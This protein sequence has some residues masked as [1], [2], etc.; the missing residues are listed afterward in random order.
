M[1]FGCMR[2]PTSSETAG[3]DSFV[4]LLIAQW[5]GCSRRGDT[6]CESGM[7]WVVMGWWWCFCLAVVSLQRWPY[8]LRQLL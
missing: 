7:E 8:T 6:G 3:R 5:A 1:V 4:D 2:S